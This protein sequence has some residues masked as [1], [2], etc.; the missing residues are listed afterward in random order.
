MFA[1]QEQWGLTHN[2]G[3]TVASK[4]LQSIAWSLGVKPERVAVCAQR[5]P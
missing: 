5:L 4:A 2:D 1:W 3:V